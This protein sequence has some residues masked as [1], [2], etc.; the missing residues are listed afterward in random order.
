MKYLIT[1]EL[2]EQKK[3]E[4][5]PGEL[6][7][8]WDKKREAINNLGKNIQKLRNK[9]SRDM[10]SSDEKLMIIAT[11]VRLIDLTG[12]RVGNDSSRDAGHHGITNLMKKHIKVNGDSVS[13]SYVGKSGIKHN[14]TVKDSKV[15]RN[16]K[17]LINKSGEVFVTDDGLSIKSTQVNDYLS[18]F[19]ITSKDL[20]GFKVN[21]L[22]SSRLRQLSIPETDGEVKKKFNEVLRDVAEEIGHTPGICRKN[23]LLPEIEEQWYNRKKVQKV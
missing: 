5:S 8:R 15:A 10:D 11:I 4:I 2:F 21:K 14:V 19:N 1:F 22:M 20:R 6:N 16:I 12:E 13:L 18:D 23:Y 3:D 9:V 17:K 7:K